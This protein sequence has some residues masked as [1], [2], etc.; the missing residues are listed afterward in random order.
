MKG[1]V[2]IEQLSTIN[3]VLSVLLTGILNTDRTAI[4]NHPVKI[5]SG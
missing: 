2:N 1:S 4:T 3:A 5:G